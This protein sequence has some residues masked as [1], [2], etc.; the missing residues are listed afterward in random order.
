MSQMLQKIHRGMNAIMLYYF[1]KSPYGS[2]YVIFLKFAEPEAITHKTHD[3]T[4][5]AGFNCKKK[6]NLAKDLF[7]S[8]KQPVVTNA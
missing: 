3:K 6:S 8:R 1:P 5:Y 2:C 4:A 7:L